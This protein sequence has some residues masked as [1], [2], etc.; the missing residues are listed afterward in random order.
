[1]AMPA[2][3]AENHEKQAHQEERSQAKEQAKAR[4]EKAM[5]AIIDICPRDLVRNRAARPLSAL[6]GSFTAGCRCLLPGDVPLL[7]R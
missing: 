1:M 7:V 2:P 6:C 4:K 3:L 5:P